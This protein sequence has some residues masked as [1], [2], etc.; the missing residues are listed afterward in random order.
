LDR[1]L[2]IGRPPG[3]PF[4]L[5][6]TVDFLLKKEFDVHR[7]KG[8]IHPLMKKYSIDAIP[9]A[10][11]EMDKW[12]EN[13]VGLQFLHKTANFLITGAVD[14]IWLNKKGELHIVDYKA[15]SSDKKP[16]LDEDY[17]S[18]YKRQIEIY[19][20]LLR[21]LGFP[22]SDI[23]YFVYVNGRRDLAAFDG[24]LEFDVQII[25]YKGSDKWVDGAIKAAKKCLNAPKAPVAKDDCAYCGYIADA[26]KIK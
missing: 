1:R 7:A 6:K 5:N 24:R 16:S 2:G 26:K 22:V 17:R 20:W 8:S 19:Q 13:F 11:A 3:F 18:G 21:K 12:R 25:A 4:N 15:T 23:G 14:D 10:H 9:F